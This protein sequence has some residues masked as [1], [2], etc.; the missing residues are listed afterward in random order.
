MDD[1]QWNMLSEEIYA[2]ITGYV[3]SGD[4]DNIVRPFLRD[5]DAVKNALNNFLESQ[6]NNVQYQQRSEG[7]TDREVLANA[8]ETTVTNDIEAFNTYDN[9]PSPISKY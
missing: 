1:K 7:L 6:R 4:V 5:Y 2:Y 8:L 9:T 3:Y